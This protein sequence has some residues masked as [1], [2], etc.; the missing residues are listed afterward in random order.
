MNRSEASRVRLA[1]SLQ[2]LYR[3]GWD[4]TKANLHTAEGRMACNRPE[5]AFHETAVDLVA[6][7]REVQP[8]EARQRADDHCVAQPPVGAVSWRVNHDR[9]LLQGYVEC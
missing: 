1:S 2:I 6:H 9:L 3:L 4:T 8:G 5:E 7:E